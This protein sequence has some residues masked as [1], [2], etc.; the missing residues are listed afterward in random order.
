LLYGRDKLMEFSI[1]GSGWLSDRFVDDWA[2][3]TGS[4][5][6]TVYPDGTP[7][8]S[9]WWYDDAGIRHSQRMR[10]RK[11]VIAQ[12][13]DL[14]SK[15]WL[16]VDNFVDHWKVD[17]VKGF[18]TSCLPVT[19]YGG[20]QA[21]LHL[22]NASHRHYLQG[23][24][25]DNVDPFG[26]LLPLPPEDLLLSLYEKAMRSFLT[27]MPVEVEGFN[28]LADLTRLNELIPRAA[29]SITQTVASGFLNWNFGWAP[30]LGD[31]KGI[32]NIL[33]TVQK[34]LQFLR[35]SWGKRTRLTFVR[36]GFW[37]PPVI[38]F[39]MELDPE[40]FHCVIQRESYRYDFR[41]QAWL[42]HHLEDLDDAL[43]TFRAIAVGLGLGNPL[44]AVWEAMPFSFILDWLAGV[45]SVL[46]GLSV[47]HIA[48]GDFW[49]RRPTT[50]VKMVG[51]LSVAQYTG[52][53]P[54][55]LD[56]VFPVNIG[57]L[58]CSRYTRWSGPPGT[59]DWTSFVSGFSG[60]QAS[61]LLAILAGTAY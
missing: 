18:A 46:A 42:T 30:F 6:A 51:R 20:G 34:R 47:T 15:P 25:G 16:Y 58:R 59:K 57:A 38:P 12:R 21:G 48:E 10:S 40:P 27:Q 1:D 23:F 35:D 28:F 54:G 26:Q 7:G 8:T 60:K 17:A 45:D 41:A 29:N 24:V 50:S 4:Q 43:T 44:G 53:Y 32:A 14:P 56:W 13:E 2:P 5:T 11:A 9:F 37:E 36:K 49:V 52:R 61:L 22:P 33:G 31:L 39:E 3:T 55:T 19:Y